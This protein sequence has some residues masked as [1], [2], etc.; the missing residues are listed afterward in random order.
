MKF[1]NKNAFTMVE[2][3]AVI[4]IIAILGLIAIMSISKLL[5]T[6]EEKYYKEQEDLMIVAGR[7][8]F[9]DNLSKRP[10]DIGEEVCIALSTLYENKYIG[11]IKDYNKKTCADDI[12]SSGVCSKKISTK[13]Y[14]YYG[15]LKCAGTNRIVSDAASP[16][17]TFAT[18]NPTSLTSSDMSEYRFKYNISDSENKI[19]SYRYI[20]YDK[21]EVQL[22]SGWKSINTSSFDGV[23]DLSI[24]STGN[25][26]I[27][28]QTYND[29]GKMSTKVSNVITIG[30]HSIDFIDHITFSVKDKNGNVIGPDYS[31][32]IYKNDIY[33]E[34][35]GNYNG[36]LSTVGISISVIRYDP[37]T[38]ND[39]EVIYDYPHVTMKNGPFKFY[40]PKVNN[41][42]VNYQII[43]NGADETL[44]FKNGKVSKMYYIDN[45]A[46]SCT[47]SMDPD[48]GWTNQNVI[49]TGACNDGK[50]SGCKQNT[51]IGTYTDDTSASQPFCSY[52]VVGAVVDNVGNYTVCPVMC[53]K[54]D[55]VAPSKP[56]ITNPNSGK[57]VSIPYN[58]TLSSSDLLSGIAKWQ[59]RK[60][61]TGQVVDINNSASNTLIWKPTVSD[62][63]G[64]NTWYF[65][66]CDNAGNC[67]DFSNTNIRISN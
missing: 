60:G 1:S 56:V 46:P 6:T 62:G 49:M 65:R 44:T 36:P 10:Q 43:V 7:D 22:D 29:K 54:K 21:Q 47:V 28:I 11:Q 34:I 32:N 33:V 48:S 5:S 31:S 23:I 17:I 25:K 19:V 18:D 4:S 38:I 45:E 61:V 12:E 66:A 67:S 50:G 9:N 64:N 2:L 59:V 20:V 40:L 24:F 13:K 16:V 57:T 51:I 52:R 8:Y 15:Y 30:Y 41:K 39:G 58:I 53:Y 3:L 42:L 35:Y 55:S 26:K 63:V 14:S 27:E 37:Y